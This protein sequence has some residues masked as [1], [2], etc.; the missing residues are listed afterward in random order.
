ML[1]AG[2]RGLCAETAAGLVLVL[3]EASAGALFD[4]FAVGQSWLADAVL[5]AGFHLFATFLAG[6]LGGCG[7]E[8]DGSSQEN[9]LEQHFGSKVLRLM[10]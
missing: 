7:C 6:G 8:A 5:G 2:R 3:E 1:S 4:V 9:I 10:S